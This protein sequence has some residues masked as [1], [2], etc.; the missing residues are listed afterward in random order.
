MSNTEHL[1]PDLIK[2]LANKYRVA[3]NNEKFMLEARLRAISEYIE[4]TLETK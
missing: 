4:K 1:I 3:R 2:D